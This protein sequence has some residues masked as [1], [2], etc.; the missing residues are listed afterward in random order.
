M[1]EQADRRAS[2]TRNLLFKGH[3]MTTTHKAPQDRMEA[4]R[5]LF[6]TAYRELDAR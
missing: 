3:F 4:V 6:G 5:R 1:F 2:T